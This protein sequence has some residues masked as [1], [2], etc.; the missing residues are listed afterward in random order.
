MIFCLS[1]QFEVGKPF[2]WIVMAETSNQKPKFCKNHVF[3]PCMSC[4]SSSTFTVKKACQVGA[5]AF[6][7]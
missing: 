3:S 1:V 5:R 4:M 2:V 6:R 7:L